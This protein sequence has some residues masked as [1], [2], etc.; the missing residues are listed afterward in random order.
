MTNTE[1]T[2]DQL[3]TVTG[4]ATAICYGLSATLLPKDQVISTECKVPNPDKKPQDGYAVVRERE[5]LIGIA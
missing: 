3:Q 4:G 2:L 1:L 5:S